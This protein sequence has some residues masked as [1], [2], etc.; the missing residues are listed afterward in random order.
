MQGIVSV[1]LM[2]FF[3]TSAL[4]RRSQSDEWQLKKDQDGIKIYSRD[5]ENSRFKEVKVVTSF[6]TTLPVLV[7]VL[8]DK[9]SLKN[10]VYK[11]TESKLLKQDSPSET[12][13]YQIADSPWPADDRDFILKSRV[14]QDSAT[15]IVEI[16][17]IGQAD[18]I[19]ES[20]KHI[21]IPSYK[22]HWT[23]T[24]AGNNTVNVVYTVS[25]DPGGNV[26]SWIINMGITDVPMHSMKNLK[27]EIEKNPDKKL[28]FIVE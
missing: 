14:S 21:R 1:L 11:C 23:L 19:P 24:P 25:L 9:N 28:D 20:R 7:G 12:Y 17:A 8:S 10:W 2:S 26:P 15:R 16:E 3:M 5:I 27:K 4:V 18:F 6:N 13:H 22:A